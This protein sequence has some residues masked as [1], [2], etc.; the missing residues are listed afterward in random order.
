MILKYGCSKLRAIEENDLDILMNLMNDSFIEE[1]TVD[2]HFPISSITQK[3]WI[4]NYKNTDQ[5]VRLMVELDNGHTIGMVILSD[6]NYKTRTAGL[7]FKRYAPKEHRMKDDMYNACVALLRYAFDEL[8]LNCITT[9]TLTY[10]DKS[11]GLQKR[12]GFKQEGVLR[13]RCFKNGKYQDLIS[14]SL[15]KNEFNG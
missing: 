2:S 1:M 13:Q 11:L 9:R 6:I 4:K 3:E 10:N 12:L 15:L 7:A 5:C 8:G 14:S